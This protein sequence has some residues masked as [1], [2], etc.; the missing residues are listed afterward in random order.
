MMY[1][2]MRKQTRRDKK[3]KT[4][5]RPDWHSKAHEKED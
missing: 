4:L 1:M 5:D 3:N 2:A